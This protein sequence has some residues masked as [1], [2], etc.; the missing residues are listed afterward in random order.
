M[1][2]SHTHDRQAQITMQTGVEVTK[3]SSKAWRTVV[4]MAKR[5]SIDQTIY[6]A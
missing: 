6:C 5:K 4:Q 2:V 1:P 3:I